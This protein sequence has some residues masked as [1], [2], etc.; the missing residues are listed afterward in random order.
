VRPPGGDHEEG[1]GA[2]D[3]G[4]AGRQRAHLRL[5][6][7]AVEDAL[8]APGMGVADELEFLAAQGMEGMGDS[9]APRSFST[10]C[11]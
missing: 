4:P 11:S 9:E 1:V 3:V 8:L 10:I 6:G 5:A 2:L 7:P